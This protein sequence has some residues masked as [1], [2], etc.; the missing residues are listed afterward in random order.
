M[1]S[2]GTRPLSVVEAL[3][4]KHVLLTGASGFLGKVWLSLVLDRVPEI[5]RLYVHLRPKALLSARAR[6]EK[7]ANT[8]PA[9][10]PLRERHGSRYEAFL[11][12]RVEVIE[13]DLCEPGL[14]VAPAVLRRLRRDVDLVVHCAGLV[15]FNPEL[16]KALASNVDA[17]LHVADFVADSERA[18]LLHVSTSFVAGRRHGRVD[19]TVVPN[20]APVGEGFDAERERASAWAAVAKIRAEYDAPAHRERVRSEVDELVR[21]KRAEA[22]PRVIET[23]V[24]RRL[25]EAVREALVEE[26][27]ARADRWGWPNTYTFTKSLAESLLSRRLPRAR[28]AIARPSIVESAH[29]FP[30]PGW[31]ESFNGTAPLAY[32][33][34]TW[35]RAVPAK[36][37]APFD[38]VP[39][40]FVCRAMATIAAALLAG[41]ADPVYHLG[42]SDRH[43]L[44]VGRAAELIVLAHRRHYRLHGTST[45]ERVVKSRWDAW[46]VEPRSLFGLEA[47]RELVHAWREALDLL[48]GR[49]R[50]KAK[51]WRERAERVDKKLD[52]IEELVE[53]YL[54]F[55]Y[56]GFHVFEC[57]ALDRI[58]PVEPAFAFDPERI[59]WRRYWIDVHM[60]GLRKWAFPL[61]EGKRPPRDRA[62]HPVSLSKSP[63]AGAQVGAPRAGEP[64]A[65]PV[66][67]EA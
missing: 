15:D 59:D 62:P 64:H 19:E 28:F 8:S 51:R 56:E 25:R 30:F 41:R 67:R 13:G 9:L 5:G 7:I 2:E 50:A 20:Y 31:N 14:G 18:R 44:S 21:E 23:W 6:F 57:A 47:S 22:S 4:G 26:G 53:L 54:P 10:R 49:V 36:P 32:V 24:R 61:I 55:M 58:R 35:F 43:R 1:T 3:R 27:M 12:E 40:D 33:M 63:P 46:L 66:A 45:A 38:V 52:Q 11:G 42:T 16:D 65:D 48:P 29:E 17:M 37:D 39:V 60:P 34:G